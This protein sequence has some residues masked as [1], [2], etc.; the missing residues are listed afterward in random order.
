MP[1]AVFSRSIIAR[2]LDKSSQPAFL[3]DARRRIVYAN[4]ALAE[5]MNVTLE[6]LDGLQCDFHSQPPSNGPHHPALCPPL[7]VFEGQSTTATVL[8]VTDPTKPLDITY[9]PITDAE[10]NF[11]AVLAVGR[12]G[13]DKTSPTD[14]SPDRLHRALAKQRQ[15]YARLDSLEYLVGNSPTIQR[16]RQQAVLASSNSSRVFVSGPAGSG[17]EAVARC[18]HASRH[19]SPAGE[20]LIPL[21][22][23]LL[24]AEML[25]TTLT[26]FIQS[27]AELETESTP[28][29]LLLDVDRL[30]PESQS[31][32][33]GFLAIEEIGLKTLTTSTLSM[34]ELVDNPDFRSDLIHSLATMEIALPPLQGRVDDIPMLAQ[35]YIEQINATGGAQRSGFSG[36][37]LEKLVAYPWP[38]N[39]VELQRRVSKCAKESSS[40]VIG[41]G[42]LPTEIRLG[43]DAVL[44]PTTAARQIDLNSVLAD[45]ERDLINEALVQS[46]RNKAEAARRL[47]ISRAKLLRRMQQLDLE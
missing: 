6:F 15:Q 44:Y 41:A 36:D 14:N 30:P 18:I 20:P 29:V 19:Q 28:S 38:G 13:S 12:P 3:L 1:S 40:P 23:D 22:C 43:I 26:A 35:W 10:S 17:K 9:L 24:D 46:K 2:Q 8:H 27:C 33:M 4:R 25:Q 31:E 5:W 16:V 7:E 42:V 47:S 45:V 34:A 21:A 32:L 11:I 39:V 37:A